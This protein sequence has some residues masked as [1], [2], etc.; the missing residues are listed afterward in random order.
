MAISTSAISASVTSTWLVS[1]PALDRLAALVWATQATE[2]AGATGGATGQI[3]GGVAAG[4]RAGAGGVGDAGQRTGWRDNPDAP[5]VE[6]LV[7]LAQRGDS[8]AFGQLYD[9]YVDTVY[10]YVYVRVGDQQLAEDITSETFLRALR[11]LDSFTWQGRDIA[12]WFVTIARNLI[13][14]HRKSSRFRLEVA[15]DELVGLDDG[16]RP[17]PTGGAA[18]PAPEAAAV[19]KA[20]DVRLVEAIRAL[21][22][23]QQECIA[24][25]FFQE[26]S[27]AETA[28]A[29]GRSQGA[30][31]QLQLRAVRALAGILGAEM[32]RE[33]AGD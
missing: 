28:L 26:F 10:R 16:R 9:L 17:T 23:E 11:R 30:I 13:A 4:G 2:T 18:P 27:V 3:A 6:A 22:P 24:L 12:A 20:R 29:M 1:A 5:R 7:E 25:R 14:D 32:E 31:K 21:K 15:T 8:E 33:L 19:T